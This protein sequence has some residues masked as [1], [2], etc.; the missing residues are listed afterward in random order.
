HS[1][2]EVLVASGGRWLVR[3]IKDKRGRRITDLLGNYPVIDISQGNIERQFKIKFRSLQEEKAAEVKQR[4]QKALN[5]FSREKYTEARKIFY[6]TLHCKTRR[7]TPVFEEILIAEAAKY[8]ILFCAMRKK[9]LGILKREKPGARRYG[10]YLLQLFREA[11]RLFGKGDYLAAIKGSYDV[12]RRLERSRQIPQVF[13]QIT[14]QR[15]SYLR[16][17][18]GS[19]WHSGE[20]KDIFFKAVKL[21]A[22]E[23]LSED[24]IES[25]NNMITIY[26]FNKKADT[27][28]KNKGREP[29]EIE[30]G[31]FKEKFNGY[32]NSNF[33]TGA[34]EDEVDIVNGIKKG[35]TDSLSRYVELHMDIVSKVVQKYTRG[36]KSDYYFRLIQEGIL[37]L[38]DIAE[39]YVRNGFNGN[40]GFEKYAE[41]ELEDFFTKRR[42]GRIK[43]TYNVLAY[44]NPI[45]SDDKNGDTFEDSLKDERLS[46]EEDIISLFDDSIDM[47]DI[48]DPRLTAIFEQLNNEE[49]K[50]IWQSVVKERSDDAIALSLG[51]ETQEVKPFL[52]RVRRKINRLKKEQNSGSPL[53]AEKVKKG[54]SFPKVNP[55][56]TKEMS[57]DSEE[58]ENASSPLKHN[59]TLPLSSGELSSFI[60]SSPL[61][62]DLM[63]AGSSLGF[64]EPVEFLIEEAKQYRVL[65][66][67]KNHLND[68]IDFLMAEAM[69]SLK[70]AGITHMGFEV[71]ASYQKEVDRF[72]E[73]GK[74]SKEPLSF[75]RMGKSE[76]V[77]F[78][79]ARDNNISIVT[80]DTRTS[81]SGNM[82][83]KFM[84]KR[85]EHSK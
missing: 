32:L 58:Q 6:L 29:I 8:H 2:V 63:R 12:E 84:V 9:A 59:P 11:V 38:Y 25:I 43:E 78:G 21:L 74:F 28:F 17:V 4:Y 65:I 70:K 40:G 67:G 42:N 83:E 54:E 35:Y 69:P 56:T 18:I 3:F 64:Q 48:K 47:D 50:V 44:N 22:K 55:A 13:K 34:F 24:I 23:E 14:L 26:N 30:A 31:V 46:S 81:K 5:L 85:M 7:I 71:D 62:Q 52:S 39:E 1:K 10:Q 82:R 77:L 57:A 16:T 41:G 51:I 20:S 61:K 76:K 60:V 37:K 45:S 33:E 68:K 53:S 27:L 79:V 49:K 15:L 19:I 73:S 72:S 80:I 66:I 36:T 75:L